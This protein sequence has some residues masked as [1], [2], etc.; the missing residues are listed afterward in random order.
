[1]FSLLLALIYVCF[2][3]LGLPDSLL[4]AAWPILHV[5]MGVPM[6][7]AGIISIVIFI[8]TI[9]SSLMSDTM[10]KKLGAGPLTAVSVA[11]TAAALP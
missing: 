6:S 9:L 7:Y 8:F 2:I 1:M 11:M 3:S 10:S 5:D 4:G